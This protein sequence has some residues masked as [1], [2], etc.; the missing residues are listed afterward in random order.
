VVDR[1]HLAYL[2]VID[3]HQGFR[4]PRSVPPADLEHFL[5]EANRLP[6]ILEIQRAMR[7]AIDPRPGMS[8]LD[9]GCG[10][11]I[12]TTRLAVENP[13]TVVTGLDRNAELLRIA[14]RRADP[15]PANLRW[16]EADLTALPFTEA[17]FDAVRT[18][19]VLMYL[20]DGAFE[21]VISDL[22]CLLC[23]GGR[24]ALF[25]LDYGATMLVPGAAGASVLRQVDEALLGLLPQ[26]LAGRRIPGLLTARGL[27]DVVA[28]P[29]SFAVSEPVWRRIVAEPL[30]AASARDS[31]IS[32]WVREQAS[33]AAR[34]EFVGA[35]TGVLTTASRP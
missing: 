20:P 1:R 15:A 2:R 26:A 32:V 7:S 14:R 34:G 18:E 5:E 33:A 3:L 31:A 11:G 13:E 16:L 23:S 10:I 30:V 35:F 9:A 12:E 4:D 24:L 25:E 21:R 29:F 27:C 28:T 6:G 22:V 8:V 19:R 17:S